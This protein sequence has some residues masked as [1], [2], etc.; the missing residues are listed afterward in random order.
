MPRRNAD[1]AWWDGQWNPQPQ[2]GKAFQRTSQYLIMRDGVR[3]AVD[4]Y[5]PKDLRPG[6]RL[7]AILCQTRYYRRISYRRFLRRILEFRDPL[8][9]AVQRFVGHGYAFVIVDVRGT[10]ASF[11]CRA[12]EWSPDEVRDGAE[13]VDWIVGQSW[14]SG[15][16]GVTGTSYSG[17][18]AE[19]IL[20]NHHPAVKAA[21]IRFALFDIF[22]DITS[23]GGVRNR[24]FLEIWHELNLALDHND[25]AALL[26][27]ETGWLRSAVIR[28]VAPVDGDDEEHLLADAVRQHEANYD[29]LAAAL[30]ADFRDDRAADGLGFDQFSPHAFRQQ[31]EQSGA[32]VYSWSSYYDGANTGAAVKRF[33]NVQSPGGRLVLGPWDH[34]GLQIPD[35]FS[36][37]AK[38]R[39]DH[40]GEVLRFFDYHLK[41]SENGMERE[42]RIHYFTMGEEKWKAADVWPP[43]GFTPTSFYLGAGRR[44]TR[45]LPVDEHAADPYRVDYSAG[46]GRQSRWE[47]LVNLA[48]VKIAYHGRRK[49]DE[50]LLVYDSEPLERAVEVTGHPV[51]TLYVRSD[52]EDGHF[53]VYLEDLSP[54]GEVHYITEGL[55][56]A[57]HRQSG[58]ESLYRLAP[59]VPFHGFRRADA[60]PLVPGEAAELSFDLLPVSHLFRRGH[61]VRVAIAGADKD[62]CELLPEL[63]PSIELLRSRHYPSR[64]LLPV[65]VR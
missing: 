14:S 33:L 43:P 50:I 5:L 22:G 62:N 53:F 7:P 63:P 12:M 59:G 55:F 13:I 16:V 38:S 44:L 61:A 21:C 65:L 49:S 57:I 32:A 56:R 4:V 51:V 1:A 31:I 11:G 26:R 58:K 19:M 10:G 52:A 9:L 29:M 64:I 45:T 40:G 37:S 17:T 30:I 20:I 23:P 15:A 3:I 28:G 48:Q 46:T 18:A 47:S 42:P 35:P 25:F 54:N 24:R 39:F 41:N 36:E 6:D 60:L 2:Y 8:R 27:R 34:G